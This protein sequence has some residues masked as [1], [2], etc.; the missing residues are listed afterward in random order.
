MQSTE[1]DTATLSHTERQD[2]AKK[3]ERGE[4]EPARQ[5][6]TKRGND[7]HDGESLMERLKE[8]SDTKKNNNEYLK[9]KEAQNK[10]GKKD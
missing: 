5:D 2:T 8:R 3:V 1:P 4:S 9:P 7:K 10:K 6:D